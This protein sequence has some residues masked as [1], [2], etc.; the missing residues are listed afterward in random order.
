[1][2]ATINQARTAI[3]SFR[4]KCRFATVR[5]AYRSCANC[6]LSSF[7]SLPHTTTT[8]SYAPDCRGGGGCLLPREARDKLPHRAASESPVPTIQN[9]MIH[10]FP[11]WLRFTPL[12]PSP[13]PP[14][15]LGKLLHSSPRLPLT[16]FDLASITAV[17]DASWG[18]P[19]PTSHVV[20]GIF[21]CVK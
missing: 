14:P 6:H 17:P 18:A 10:A 2:Y 21:D 3:I 20:G 15:D 19:S 11:R 8:H 7:R 5:H 13:S 4:L 16:S 1:M 9:N 12:R